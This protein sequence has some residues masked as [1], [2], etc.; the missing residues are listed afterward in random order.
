MHLCYFEENKSLSLFLP[1]S[2]SCVFLPLIK[3]LLMVCVSVYVHSKDFI[4][5]NNVLLLTNMIHEGSP[6]LA[7]GKTKTCGR[8]GMFSVFRRGTALPPPPPP[9]LMLLMLPTPRPDVSLRV[10]LM[11]Q[12]TALMSGNDRLQRKIEHVRFAFFGHLVFESFMFP[13]SFLLKR[14]TFPAIL[15]FY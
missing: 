13:F 11:R 9:L 12:Q 7:D 6:F 10:S 1:S 5:L 2:S 3:P 4:T 14:R 8:L 15:T